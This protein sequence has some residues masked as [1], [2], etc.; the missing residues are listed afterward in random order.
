[1]LGDVPSGGGGRREIFRT[2][3]QRQR[4]ERRSQGVRRCPALRE[5]NLMHSKLLFASLFALSIPAQSYARPFGLPG[6]FGQRV[7]AETRNVGLAN[8][9]LDIDGNS[10][11]F[12]RWLPNTDRTVTSFDLPI[13]LRAPAGTVPV[14][15]NAYFYDASTS[16]KPGNELARGQ[17]NL[18]TGNT[19]RRAAVYP[20]CR[21]TGGQFYFLVIDVPAAGVSIDAT[22]SASRANVGYF[23]RPNGGSLSSLKNH[24]I[25]LR[26]NTD[27]KFPLIQAPPPV[28]G[29]NWQVRCSPVPSNSICYFTT[30]HGDQPLFVLG[31]H[32]GSFLYG[33]APF[34]IPVI[35]N[36]DL[37]T[38][39][40]ALPNDPSWRGLTF[41]NQFVFPTAGNDLAASNPL[42][43]RL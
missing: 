31:L 24:G 8:T 33:G 28:L 35:S 23:V 6:I 1:M 42:A 32:M 17:M 21:V 41:T 39:T 20:E 19:W 26:I 4:H 38:I 15:I 40:F 27:G 22:T 11:L 3:L 2:D 36:G 10:R 14:V 9:H 37:A 5:T 12:I 29:T 7:G 34:F 25:V 18:S 43:V 16:G 30:S 13:N